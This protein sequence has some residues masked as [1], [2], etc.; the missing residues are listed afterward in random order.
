M[1]DSPDG[2]DGFLLETDQVGVPL[3]AFLAEVEKHHD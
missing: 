3:T 2:H 1:I